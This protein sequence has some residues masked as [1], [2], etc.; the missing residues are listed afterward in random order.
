M[1]LKE[2]DETLA[3]FQLENL[4]NRIDLQVDKNGNIAMTRDGQLQMGNTQSNA[5]FRLVE[6]WRESES[7]INELFIP[8]LR[9]S[10]QLDELSKA[11]ERDKGA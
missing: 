6:R 5:I 7:T 9:A 8:M 3:Q 10:S 2:Y 11:R 4:R 1:P